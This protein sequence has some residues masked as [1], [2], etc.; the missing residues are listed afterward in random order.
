MG[1][2]LTINYIDGSSGSGPDR[3]EVATDSSTWT[4]DKSQL[5][6]VAAGT[7]S[8]PPSLVQV[9]D[10]QGVDDTVLVNQLMTLLP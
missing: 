2:L 4:L 10:Q 6:D 3:V 1:G 8:L 5:N 7:A 9:L